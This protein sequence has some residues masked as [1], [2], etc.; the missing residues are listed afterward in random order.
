M[1][2]AEAR[3][4][5]RA[6]YEVHGDGSIAMRWSIDAREALPNPVLPPLFQCVN[7]SPCDS[8]IPE[9]P[10]TAFIHD[11]GCRC[12][13]KGSSTLGIELDMASMLENDWKHHSAPTICI[14]MQ[15]H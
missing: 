11:I 1:P 6:A 15:L 2:A 3:V 9:R 14:H 13:H 4:G 12:T 8:P 10:L 5:V 7:G